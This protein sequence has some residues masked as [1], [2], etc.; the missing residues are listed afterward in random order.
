MIKKLIFL[1]LIAGFFPGLCLSQKTSN[2]SII[3]HAISPHLFGIFFED[4]SHA[5]DGGLY[6]E[7]IQNRSFEFTP[8]DHGGWNGF[9]FWNYIKTGFGYGEIS[10]H[11]NDPV[12][13]NNEHYVV[14][15]IDEA[16]DGVGISNAGYDNGIPVEAGTKYFFSV[17][18]KQLSDQPVK[19][20]VKIAGEDGQIYAID[21][22]Y[23]TSTSWKKYTDTFEINQTNDK[24]RLYLLGKSLGKVAID[25]VSLFPDNTFKGR[26]NGLRKDIAQT[27]VALKPTF[28]RFPGGCLTHGDGIHNIYRWQNTIGPLAQRKGQ[29]NIWGYHQSVGLGYYEYFQFSE[30]IGAEPVPVVAAGV[31]CQNS[32]GSWR[33]G[34]TGQRGIPMED[35][36]AYIQSINNLIEY[37]N[38]PVTSEWGAKRAAAGHPKPFNLKYVGIGNEDKITPRFKKR[39]K[40]IYDAVHK[41]HPEITLIGTSGPF[42][43]GEDYEKG[44]AFAHQLNLPMVDEH[45]YE[46]PEWFLNNQH[47][48]DDYDRSKSKVYLGEYASKGNTLYNALCE[49]AY[50][51]SLERN[52]DVVSMASYA[53]LL[54]RIGHTNW[55]PNLIYFDKTGV[56]PTVNYYVQKL[57]S[58]NSGIH[59]YP[60]V[61]SFDREDKTLAQSCV[62]D[63]AGNIILKIVNVSKEPA[64]AYL[65]LSPF[66]GFDKEAH[67]KL[68][69][70]DPKDEDTRE[71]PDKVL[72]KGKLLKVKNKTTYQV[73]P[74]SLSVIR[75][76]KK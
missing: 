8:A 16:G 29:R 64:K 56:Y 5:A 62:V 24:A 35:M 50:M 38:G 22:F 7:M 48:Y 60:E 63:S 65:D 45:Y 71:H 1:I 61:V 26:K 10:I 14:L 72:P 6:A 47:F 30:D 37:A 55:N 9:S 27:I 42:H 54:G 43:E 32:G 52:G 44:W 34:G 23:T 49:A 74:Y 28:M 36:D 76:K 53:P 18:L 4:I 12:S 39:F 46:D 67:L 73:P 33:V 66:K 2:S 68:L 11:T 75:I 20:E 17:F 21:S 70:G 69:Q 13:E 3:D 15:E 59:Y 58:L 57:F 19:M 41:E 31:S 40:M 25:M 51:T